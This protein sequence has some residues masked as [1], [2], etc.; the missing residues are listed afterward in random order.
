MVPHAFLSPSRF[1]LPRPHLFLML[2][3]LVPMLLR[4]NRFLGASAARVPVA[5]TQMTFQNPGASEVRSH[6]GAWERVS[7]GHAGRCF[8]EAKWVRS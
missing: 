3:F 6:A 4:G 5:L 7:E 2:P 8:Q 1:F